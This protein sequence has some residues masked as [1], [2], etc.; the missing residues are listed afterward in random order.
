MSSYSSKNRTEAVKGEGMENLGQS[1]YSSKQQQLSEITFKSLKGTQTNALLWG[2]KTKEN[3]S[4][5]FLQI[6]TCCRIKD[7]G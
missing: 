7:Q 5:A 3:Q 2:T 6:V 1:L 4:H